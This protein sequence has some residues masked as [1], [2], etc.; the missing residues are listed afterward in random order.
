MDNTPP[1]FVD[2][3]SGDYYLQPGSSGID[4]G[5][6]SGAPADDIVG[7]SRGLDGD[8]SGAGTGDSSDYDMGAY[9]HIYVP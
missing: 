8:N 7:T 9:E 3:A 6:N 2:A 4:T 5:T 1:T